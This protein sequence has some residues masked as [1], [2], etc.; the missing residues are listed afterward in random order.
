MA[1]VSP[2]CKCVI[3]GDGAVGK[4]CLLTVYV[5]NKFPTVYVP[6]IFENKQTYVQFRDQ[7]VTFM[8]WD[9]AGQEEFDRLRPLSYDGANVILIAYSVDSETSV[10]NI[11]SKWYPEVSHYCPSIPVVLVGTKADLRESEECK[12]RM[13]AKGYAMV[14]EASVKA[15]AKQIG[16]AD[17]VECSAKSQHNVKEVFEAAL[18]A[19]FDAQS[20]SGSGDAQTCSLM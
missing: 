19:A 17:L 14:T 15:V 13:A 3:V 10:E 4:T 12:N 1:P 18:A 16:A 9:T 2:H 20:K 5:E 11:T 7:T 8:L 6:T